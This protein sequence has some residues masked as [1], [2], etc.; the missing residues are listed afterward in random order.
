MTVATLPL[1]LVNQTI[2]PLF[3]AVVAAARRRQAGVLFRG[4]A[5]RRSSGW[6]RLFTWGGYS[7][8]LGWHLLVHGRRYQHLLVVSNP[9]FAP[10]LAPLSR[11]P[12]ALLLYDLYPQVLA[13]LQPRNP[14]LKWLLSQVA[15]LWQWA[16]R[17]VFAKA[18]R[19]FTLSEAMAAELR[20]SFESEFSWRSKV[21]VI[22]PWADTARLRPV[23]AASNPFRRQHR[24]DSRLLVTYSG[25]LGFT[26][27][28]EALLEAAAKLNSA[29]QVLLIG[30][31]P[32]R[33]A[34]EELARK[35]KLH[36]EALRFLA[37]L[38]L[39][40]LPFRSAAS[41]LAVVALDGP[42]AAAALPSK[43]FPALACGTPLLAL[44]P[45]D[46]ALAALVQQH[47]CGVVVPPGPTAGAELAATIT[48]LDHDP[49]RRRQLA[50][51]ALEASRHYTPANAEQLVEVW[52][53][54]GRSDG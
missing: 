4:L 54:A 45:T 13:Q 31:G 5:Y 35:L 50:A 15:R 16:N 39:E 1:L 17:K 2:G 11:R 3:A 10:L 30:T 41:D 24:L 38:P 27:P 6:T 21:V 14:L 48:S 42:P 52:L 26:H 47:G 37:P 46:S 40:Q 7:L 49:D 18:E 32:K 43:T 34:L 23:P 51:A 53:G 36:P 8:Q 20:S 33:L 29:V 25:N 44:A 28:L 22:P 19:V 12:Y 9:P